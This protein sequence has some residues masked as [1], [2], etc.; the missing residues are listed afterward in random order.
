MVNTG[1]RPKRF[2]VLACAGDTRPAQRH[3]EGVEDGKKLDLPAHALCEGDHFIQAG[4]RRDRVATASATRP[5][6]TEIWPVSTTRMRS[7]LTC[8]AAA[9]AAW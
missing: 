1:W 3:L 9:S 4:A 8:F 5:S 6:E 2:A 7:A